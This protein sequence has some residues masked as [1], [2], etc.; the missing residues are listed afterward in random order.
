VVDTAPAVDD[1][2]AEAPAPVATASTPTSAV[3]APEAPSATVESDDDHESPP[4]AAVVGWT[5]GAGLAAALLALAAR[6]RRRLPTGQR[7]ARPPK[8]AVELG[9]AML[10]TDNV[11]LVEWASLALR[12]LGS[13]LRPRP[14]EP[15][16]V[17]RL[18]RLADD[19]VE[20]VWDS[21]HEPVIAPWTT[22]DGGW[23]WN[24][25]RTEQLD[26]RRCRRAVPG[27]RHHRSA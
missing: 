13:R 4:I 18:L 17:P 11:S 23:S 27:A 12:H 1:A 2:P 22:D 8:R 25:R 6:R 16:P 24:I 15:T 7:H 26:R 10:E 19:T 9:I 14:G 21:P 20:I 3:F 5:G